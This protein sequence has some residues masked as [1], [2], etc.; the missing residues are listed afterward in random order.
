M[1]ISKLNKM[2]NLWEKNNLITSEQNKNI[3]DF[4]KERQKEQFFR[5]IKWFFILGA[6]WL[7]FGLIASIIQ[8]F[9]L[10]FM[11]NIREFLVNLFIKI[12]KPFID[13]L[14]K[15]FGEKLGFF[16]GGISCF[17]FYGITA[18]ISSKVDTAKVAE[19][20]NLTENQKFILNGNLWLEVVACIL[21][22]LG[23]ML[24]NHM[25]I[26]ESMNYYE[27]TYKIFPAWHLIGALVF[28]FLAY[29]LNK[30]SHLLFGLYFVSLTVG[31][32]SGY[33]YACYWIGASRPIIQALVGFILILIGYIT[34]TKLKNDDEIKEKFAQTYNWVGLLTVFIALWIMSFWGFDFSYES[35]HTATS[36]ELWTANILF[37]ISCLGSMYYGAK[38]EHKIFFN[39]G[40]TFLIIETYTLFCSRL[41]DKLPFALSSL[42]F[43]LLLIGTGK[44]LIKIYFKNAKSD[45]NNE[46][47]NKN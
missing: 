25:L 21:L 46:K 5:C 28:I 41:W 9:D 26:P 37:I 22:A 18:F 27:S 4:M 16:L 3:V 13:F 38:N 7:I 34:E 29:K 35:H 11:E 32:L 12:S 31:M 33:D 8:F 14:Q 6:F 17:V 39:Y 23:F 36:A 2:L 40:L 30:V 47:E 1:R 24:F 10:S 19:K 43:G 42:I 15:L 20:L 45:K 44:L